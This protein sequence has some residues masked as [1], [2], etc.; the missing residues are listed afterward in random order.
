MNAFAANKNF[1][2]KMLRFWRDWSPISIGLAFGCLTGFALS[3][4]ITCA[5]HFST[6]RASRAVEE[7]LRLTKEVVS[8]PGA[9]VMQ[10]VDYDPYNPD[11]NPW[12]T[13]AFVALSNA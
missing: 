13:F 12:L 10:S 8:V 5:D 7:R 11:A 9:I 3:A 4:S 6:L 1:A 2:P